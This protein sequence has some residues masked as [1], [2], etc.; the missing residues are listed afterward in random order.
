MSNSISK[1]NLIIPIYLNEKTVL[2][3]LAILE[4]G[5]SMISEVTAST[6]TNNESSSNLNAGISTNTILSKLLKINIGGNIENND[7]SNKTEQRKVDKIHTNTSLF[8]KLKSELITNK[9]ISYIY[10]ED[11]DITKINTGDFIELEGELQK[12]PMIDVIQKFLDLFRIAKIFDETLKLGK[13][14]SHSNQSKNE[15]KIES[16]MQTFLDELKNSGTID[17]IINNPN[18]TLILSAQEKYLENDNISEIIGGK[19]RILGKVIQICKD[20]KESINL[21]RKTSLSVLDQEP[22]NEMLSIMNNEELEQFNLPKVEPFIT[23]PAA[24]IIPI[25]MYT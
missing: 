16:Q 2:D 12:N 23:G 25:A 20:D 3:L 8:S 15:Q 4:D 14:K 6:Q 13:K 5:F 17:F 18:A 1:E 24:I 22:L 9:L 11:I 21:L 19:F 10:N 7:S